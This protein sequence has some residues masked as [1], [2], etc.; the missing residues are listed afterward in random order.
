[1]SSGRIDRVRRMERKHMQAQNM[2]PLHVVGPEDE[3]GVCDL[4]TLLPGKTPRLE[5]ILTNELESRTSD[6]NQHQ[7]QENR[8]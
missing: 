3:S 8:Q 2:R 1:M 7:E 6:K 4:I 5:R